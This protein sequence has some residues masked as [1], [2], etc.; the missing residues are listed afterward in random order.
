MTSVL[1]VRDLSYTYDK[2]SPFA[3]DALHHLS[4]DV[5]PGEIIG[6]VGSTGSGKSTLVQ[7]LNGLIPTDVGH[8]FV[9][10]VDIWE[11][12][13][14]INKI[15]QKVGLV[16]QYPEYQLFEE[17]VYDDI[18]F[19]PRNAGLDESEVG[20]RVQEAAL[21][22]GLRSDQMNMSPF[23]FSGGQK[24]R[25]AIAGVI[26]MR[27]DVL[28]MDEPSAGLD[29]LGAH[30][31]FDFILQY[32][33]MTGAAVLI[34]SHHMEDMATVADRLLVLHQGEQLALDTTE[35]IFADANLLESCGLTQPAGV[36][37]AAAL[38]QNGVPLRN[39]I[40]TVDELANDLAVLL[41]GGKC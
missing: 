5:E 13:K 17:T 11:K 23:D 10:G 3:T 41:K 33:K 34:V 18:A 8:I 26:A 2:N 12:P 20:H 24:R 27:P 28:V 4:F 9:Q 6:I 32:R 40:L 16:F 22:V 7:H 39:D 19:G 15:R 36:R 30:Q 1:S 37:L 35:R 14:E 29:P 31:I 38:R 25:I 21:A